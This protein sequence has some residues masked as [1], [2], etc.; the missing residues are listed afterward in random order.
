MPTLTILVDGSI[1][2]A[3]DFNGNYRRLNQALGVNTAIANWAPGEIPYA[4]ST[5]TLSRLPGG[6]PG[7]VLT[8]L[9]GLPG[10]SSAGAVSGTWAQRNLQGTLAASSLSA[11]A[12]A[13]VLRASGG[14]IKLHESVGALTIDPGTAGLNGR[15]Q[16][17]AFTANQD[18][19]AYWI[20]NGVFIRGVWAD[21]APPT[22]PDLTTLPAFAGYTHW[23]PILPAKWTAG[24]AFIPATVRGSHVF[25]DAAQNVVA[26]GLAI[27][28]TAVSVAAFVPAA[29]PT[30]TA[31]LGGYTSGTANNLRF[32]IKTG[33]DYDVPGMVYPIPGPTREQVTWPNLGQQY[34]YLY[35]VA[36]GATAGH[37]GYV[38]GYTVA[39]GSA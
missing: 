19:Y 4:S 23:C 30:W 36:P 1:P 15:D 11:S 18:L 28:E 22:G 35:A 12:D 5:D 37:Y 9:A 17:A 25:Y 20:S 31:L 7:D 38:R 2:V 32:R 3:E 10:W 6:N 21:S 24:A 14:S 26:D 16:A 33:L 8:M 34:F 39:N 27:T 29:A 13:V